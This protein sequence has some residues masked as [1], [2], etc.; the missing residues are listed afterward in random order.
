MVTLTYTPTTGPLPLP[1]PVVDPV[2]TTATGSFSENFDRQRE[3]KGYSWNVVASIPSG[4]GYAAASS[5]ACAVP[6]P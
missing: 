2:T 1:S 5:P 4:D 3:G 6:I